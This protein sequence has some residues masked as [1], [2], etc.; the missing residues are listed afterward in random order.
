VELKEETSSISATFMTQFDF[1]H[2]LF[3]VARKSY[4]N[5]PDV[6]LNAV[7]QQG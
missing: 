2:S 5:P 6:Q 3:G 7:N 4:S 1:I